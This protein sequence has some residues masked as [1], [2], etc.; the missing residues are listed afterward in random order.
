MLL[1]S[2]ER[3]WPATSPQPGFSPG[4]A[5]EEPEGGGKG[6]KGWT[7]C[8]FFFLFLGINVTF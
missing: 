3:G 6:A 7:S 2:S 8:H 1:S 4:G 5:E